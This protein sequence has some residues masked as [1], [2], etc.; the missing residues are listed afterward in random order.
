[1]AIGDS[2]IC[3]QKRI[4]EESPLNIENSTLRGKIVDIS[5]SYEDES[6]YNITIETADTISREINNVFGVVSFYNSQ[7]A[8]LLQIKDIGFGVENKGV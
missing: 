8:L 4:G 7:D 1:M 5:R 6:L 3:E 2:V